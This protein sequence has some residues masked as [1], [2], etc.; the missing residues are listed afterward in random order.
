MSSRSR[1]SRGR[2]W[3]RR[4]ARRPCPC[5]TC[6]ARAGARQRA[7]ALRQSRAGT[8]RASAPRTCRSLPPP[9][10]RRTRSSSPPRNPSSTRCLD[11]ARRSAS[12]RA[13][14]GSGADSRLPRRRRRR[15]S[16]AGRGWRG[17]HHG[18]TGAAAP[19]S[20]AGARARPVQLH[21]RRVVHIQH[22]S[23]PLPI[24]VHANLIYRVDAAYRP[25]TT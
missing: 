24:T 12:P 18:P 13:S 21:A 20:S 17:T 14:R 25:H 3:R 8:A 22:L 10:H 5:T 15:F 11:T 23:V 16:P 1:C 9:A 4:R 7:A 6:P 2:S 19:C